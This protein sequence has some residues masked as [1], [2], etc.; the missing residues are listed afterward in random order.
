M[1]VGGRFDADMV[2]ERHVGGWGWDA[3]TTASE[4]NHEPAA[5]EEHI[6]TITAQGILDI[7]RTINL[8]TTAEEVKPKH[9]AVAITA[10]GTKDFPWMQVSAANSTLQSV[11]LGAVHVGLVNL[12]ATNT[13]LHITNNTIPSIANPTYASITAAS[14][15]AVST[16][17]AKKDIRLFEQSGLDIVNS[18]Q[19]VQYSLK[20]EN[21]DRVGFIAEWTNKLL[22][23]PKQN[24]NDIGTTLGIALKAIQELSAE[25]RE[26]K[27]KMHQ[28][29]V[30]LS[31]A[32]HPQ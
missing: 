14:F 13:G 27:E 11:Q 24:Q 15:T 1:G 9:P 26:L 8:Y 23:G 2:D 29:E 19:I 12:I 10:K 22:S 17:T 21:R 6:P 3:D 20:T 28:L 16:I 4:N 5:R 32:S 31:Q 7:G 18:M 30:I 25:N